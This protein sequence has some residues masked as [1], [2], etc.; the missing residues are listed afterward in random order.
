MTAR[1]QSIELSTD[2]IGD[3]LGRL[4][5]RPVEGWITVLAAL[6]MVTLVGASFVEAGWTL[7]EK[8]G[9]TGF[10]LYVGAIG[11]TFGFAGAKIGWGRWRTHI[12]GALFAGLLLPLIMGGLVLEAQ[13][14]SVGWDPAGLAARMAMASNVAQHVWTDL[15]VLRLPFTQ[16]EGHYHLV[17]GAIVWGAGLLA[18]YTIFGHRR[19][20]DAVVVVGL[21]LLA[22]MAI[23]GHDQLWMLVIFSAAALLLL[24]R[25]HVF[26]EQVTWVRRKIGDPAAVGRLYIKGGA[27]FVTIAILSAILLTNAASSAPL[28][29]LWRDLPKHLAGLSQMLQALAPGGGDFRPVGGP[30]FGSSA[31]TSGQWN[32]SNDIAFEAE[33]PAGEDASFK[34]RAGAYDHYDLYGWSRSQGT[35]TTAGPGDALLS[36]AADQPST[37]GRRPITLTIVPEAYRDQT[38]IGPNAISSVDRATVAWTLGKDGWFG[39]VDSTQDIA[40][41]TVKAMIPVSKDTAGALT[42]ADL[43]A[44]GTVYPREVSD[45]YLQLPDEALGANAKGLLA[46]IRSRVVVPP[47]FDPQNPYDLARTM[48]SYLADSTNFTYDA[49]VTQE[50]LVCGSASTVECFATIKRG[51]CEYY[52]GAMVAMLRAANV[53]ARIAYGFL[54][55]KDSRGPNNVEEVKG[56]LAH[57]WVEVYFPGTGWFEFDPTGSVGQRSPLPS[58][59]IGPSTPRPSLNLPSRNPVPTFGPGGGGATGSSGSQTGIGP[60]IAIALILLLGVGA[61]VFAALRRTPSRPMH[62]DQ[63]WGSVAGLASRFGLGPRP[64]QTVYEYAGALGDEV[65]TARVELTTIAR[66]KV[67]VVYGHRDLEPDRL[68]RV[69]QAYQRLRLAILGVVVRRGLRRVRGRGRGRGRG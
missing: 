49:N 31:T 8:S 39:T 28:Q 38:V 13:G 44:A 34:W 69:A 27:A 18:G 36:G 21:V 40:P 4:P 59:S 56:S 30:T 57:W 14:I 23:T 46:T 19:P 41:Y 11:F 50:R 63:A 67:E 10:L 58:G 51:Y 54:G 62:P 55:N 7:R 52:A 5:R 43:R 47:G 29:G 35:N 9:D 1:T 16:Q 33:L 42:E 45:I 26:E 48:E 25:T 53:P 22:N 20:L 12:V 60:F 64:S 65:P 24:I 3:V 37:A 15:A 2:L 17:F 68:K 66:A 61:L 32:P 6:T